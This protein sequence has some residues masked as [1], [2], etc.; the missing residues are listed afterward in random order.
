[1]YNNIAVLERFVATASGQDCRKI[2][3]ENFVGQ[4]LRK[5]EY[6]FRNKKTASWCD[7]LVNF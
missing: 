1:M 5:G 4:V 2:T 7:R 3:F 6:D